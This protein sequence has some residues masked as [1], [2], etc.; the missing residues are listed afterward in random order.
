MAWLVQ[1]PASLILPGSVTLVSAK[2]NSSPTYLDENSLA[3][4]SALNQL[5]LPAS[6]NRSVLKRRAD[7]AAGRYCAQAALKLAGHK[8]LV[9][10]GSREDRSPVWPTGWGGSITHTEGYSCAAVA[11]VSDIRGLGI[12]SEKLFSDELT[13]EVRSKVLVASE[14]E[15]FSRSIGS[16]LSFSRYVSI[17]FAAKEG[18]FKAL[19]PLTG[20]YF[21]MNH[22]ELIAIDLDSGTARWRLLK[23]LSKE[24]VAGKEGQALFCL[25]AA[26]VHAGVVIV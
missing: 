12:D 5:E 7:Y 23:E 26:Y 14:L 21:E 9:E 17:V 11:R 24:F 22:A 19:N 8:D 15:Y 20:T 10:I 3:E 2:L 1:T 18:L 16:A 13:E 6:L 4:F 25:D